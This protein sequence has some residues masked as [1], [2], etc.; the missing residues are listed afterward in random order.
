MDPLMRGVSHARLNIMPAPPWLQNSGGDPSDEPGDWHRLAP[1]PEGPHRTLDQ[2]P[3]GQVLAAQDVALAAPTAPEGATDSFHDVEDVNHAHSPHEIGDQ[4]GA[5]DPLQHLRPAIPTFEWPKDER[6]VYYDRIQSALCPGQHDFLRLTLGQGIARSAIVQIKWKIFI[7][8]DCSL[9]RDADR[10]HGTDVKE[11]LDSL[12]QASLHNVTCAFDIDAP[13]PLCVASLVTHAGC[14]MNDP[15]PVFRGPQHTAPIG[16]I[17]DC[18][19]NGKSIK[20]VCRRTCPAQD[21][22]IMAVRDHAATQVRT[23]KTGPSRYQHPH[24]YTVPRIATAQ[25]GLTH[26]RS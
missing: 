18:T 8:R 17:P 24:V 4:P 9:V 12:L 6:R 13:L 3:K 1:Q 16:H 22:D 14:G 23:E 20:R 11:S 7:C 10:G 25:A 15:I 2:G 5:A 21:A 26:K 19:L